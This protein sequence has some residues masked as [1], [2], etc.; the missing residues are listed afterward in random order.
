MT[1]SSPFVLMLLSVLG[2][3]GFLVGVGG[4]VWW[5]IRRERRQ[6]ELSRQLFEMK[7]AIREEGLPD[8]VREELVRQRE[9]QVEITREARRRLGL[10]EDESP[11]RG[12]WG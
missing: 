5:S 11:N 9:R 12:T 2:F 3:V 10:P 4:W 7:Q 8:D 1:E 6:T